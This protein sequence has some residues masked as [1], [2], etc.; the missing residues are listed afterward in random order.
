MKISRDSLPQWEIERFSYHVVIVGTG[1]AGMNCAKKLYEYLEIQGVENPARHIALV[2]AGINLGASRMSGSDKQTYYKLGTSPDTPDSAEEFAR[3]LT[4]GGSCHYDLA[5]IEA[6]GSLRGFY[7]LVEAGVPFPHDQYGA[8]VGYKTDHDPYE[9]AT[10]AGPRTSRMMSECLEK[11]VRN[12]GIEIFDNMEVAELLKLQDEETPYIKGIAAIDKHGL[13]RNQRA[14]KVFLC[15][16]LVLA[17]GGPGG[18]YKTSVYP[19]GQIGMHGIALKAGLPA[20]NLTES[21]FGLSSTKFRW[22]VSGT[23]MQVIPRIFS[24]DSD[25]SDER[26]FLNKFFPDMRRMASAIFL[27][28][29]QWPFDPQRVCDHQS[30][31][32]DLLVHKE[33][34]NGRRVFLDFSENPRKNNGFDDFDIYQLEEEAKNYLSDNGAIQSLPIE[35]LLHMNPQAIDLYKENGIDLYNEPLEI[36]VCAQH[37]NGG[38][39]V[40]KWWQSSIPNTFVIGEMAGTHGVKRPGGSALNAG[41]V[42]AERSAQYITFLTK[43]KELEVDLTD[44]QYDDIDSIVKGLVDCL[45]D[46]ESKLDGYSADQIIGEV[47]NRMSK[48]AAHLRFL[49][50]VER[51]LVEAQK[52]YKT[53][54]DTGFSANSSAELVKSLQASHLMLAS[55]AYLYAIY[56]LL[57]R[58]GGSRGSYLVLSKDGKVIHQDLYQKDSTL[59]LTYVEE[60]IALRKSIQKVRCEA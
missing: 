50:D 49:P 55:V 36:A 7:N 48:Y 8:Y 4:A 15:N 29:Y 16:Y 42:G 5:M 32:I 59:L 17:G 26:D 45:S 13:A 52:L 1:A 47:Q 10:S 14:V 39:A 56:D 31:L 2:T 6:I 27:K 51:A 3:S 34:S 12:Y 23:Y 58:G 19:L 57:K 30:S 60:N 9:R 20:E 28:G 11:S 46:M 53:V 44:N 21:Q 18:L 24:N 35:R 41:Q 43:P 37:N 33:V 25:G 22:N 38:F 40:N 54:H